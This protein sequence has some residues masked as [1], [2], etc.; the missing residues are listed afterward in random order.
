MDNIQ[1]TNTGTPAPEKTSASSIISIIVIVLVIA[2]GAFYFLRQVPNGEETADLSTPSE[3][4]GDTTLSGL[5]NQ[6]TST[7]IADIEADLNATDLSGVD[8]GLTNINL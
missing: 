7:N 5:S 8:A 3:L 2:L 1:E 6:G 4:Q